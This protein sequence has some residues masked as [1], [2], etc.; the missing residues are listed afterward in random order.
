MP[1]GTC[2]ARRRD[3]KPCGARASSAEAT[4]CAHHE[5]LVVIHGEEAVRA[6]RVPRRRN[7]RPEEVLMLE[8]TPDP[9]SNG[10]DAVSPSTISPSEIRSVLATAAAE[11]V[12]A[13][14]EAIRS[15]AL[16]ALKES[17]HTFE[18]DDC[19]KKKRVRVLVPDVRARLDALQIWLNE[20]LGKIAQVAGPSTPTL[21]TD[22]AKI[23][24]LSWSDMRTLA[25]I[26]DRDLLRLEIASLNEDQKQDLRDAL[27]EP[28]PA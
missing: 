10:N 15:A 27:A 1:I 3:G 4:F 13:I 5:G 25:V 7:P 28:S 6:G 17:W 12:E 11:D 26:H 2:P 24:G 14:R 9:A 22:P 21:P 23:D 18:C 20:S 8:D 19:G 16:G